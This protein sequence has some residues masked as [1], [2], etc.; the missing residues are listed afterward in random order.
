MAGQVAHGWGALIASHLSNAPLR[1]NAANR[2]TGYDKASLLG[3]GPCRPRKGSRTGTMDDADS[4]PAAPH[5]VTPPASGEAKPTAPANITPAVS[6]NITPP[7]PAE[8]APSASDDVAVALEARAAGPWAHD[9]CPGRPGRL[10]HPA[11]SPT[12]P[13]T[14]GTRP[15]AADCSG[16]AGS[17][18]R[19]HTHHRSAGADH[20]AHR[21]DP[22]RR[23]QAAAGR[24][25]AD[26][27][28]WAGHSPSVGHG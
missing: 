5:E 11:E 14:P 28:S 24:Q 22:H 2:V 23:D 3:S 12:A 16:R 21:L 18:V 17:Q 1:A 15:R 7:T 26:Q 20:R 6:A 19:G 9:R 13:G 8:V 25:Q 10:G 27:R 4:T